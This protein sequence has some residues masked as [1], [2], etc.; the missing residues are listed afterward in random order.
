MQ[1][2]ED[3]EAAAK[4]LHV[5]SLRNM[6]EDDFYEAYSSSEDSEGDEN[7]IAMVGDGQKSGKGMGKAKRGDR[8]NSELQVLALG[9]STGDSAK[10]ERLARDV[11]KMSKSQKLSL[12]SAESPELLSLLSE[13][14]E[15]VVLFFPQHADSSSRHINYLVCV[16]YSHI[17][18][19]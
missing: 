8:L 11:S 10:V 7:E 6:Q 15:K 3:E 9:K 18:N 12:L 4:D 2:A 1:D 5:E 14:R 16:S 19:Y 17:F 13:L